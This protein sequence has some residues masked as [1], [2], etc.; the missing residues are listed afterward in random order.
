MEG[1]GTPARNMREA[2]VCLSACG[3]N[4]WSPL[5]PI[6]CLHRHQ[7]FENRDLLT[8]PNGIGFLFRD[9]TSNASAESGTERSVE[10]L[11][12]LTVAQVWPS[13]ATMS[14]RS[15]LWASETLNPVSHRNT[16]KSE[17]S[18]PPI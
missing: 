11:V 12:S 3:T 9:R 4:C 1:S 14:L 17:Y 7:S 10:F 15:R 16:T 18:R 13:T 2:R 6:R 5:R 8:P